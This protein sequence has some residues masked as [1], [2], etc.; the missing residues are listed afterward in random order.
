MLSAFM[1]AVYTKAVA[2]EVKRFLKSTME[3]TFDQAKEHL[4][5]AKKEVAAS[6]DANLQDN[7]IEKMRENM[8]AAKAAVDKASSVLNT[9]IE[10]I[11]KA[12][13]EK[14][15]LERADLEK[16]NRR[17]TKGSD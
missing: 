6:F 10:N 2:P 9:N 11:N 1:D 12:N 4:A 15:A 3:G 17:R 16:K 7:S 8:K 5:K 14:L 13:E